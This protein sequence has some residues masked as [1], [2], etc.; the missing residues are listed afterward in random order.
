MYYFSAKK[1]LFYPEEMKDIY[2]STDSFP[3]DV[4]LVDNSVFNEF[5]ANS[6][7]EGKTRGVDNKGKPCW[8]DIAPLSHEQW[9]DKSKQQ[10]RFLLA[11]A[12][13]VIAP[14]KDAQDGGY[15]EHEDIARLISW[16]K[17]RYKLTKVDFS[18]YPNIQWPEKP[19]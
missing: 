10:Q 9:L 15:I 2:I 11:H 7:P 17:Y 13:E 3:D 19:Q 12:N 6:P 14:L 1:N 8:L 18:N 16:Q 4:I 5:V